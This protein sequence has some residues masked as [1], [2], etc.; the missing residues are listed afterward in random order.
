MT[1][2]P[3]SHE[4]LLFGGFGPGCVLVCN[5]TWAFAHGNWTNVVSST[6]CTA[7]TCP[8]ARA[9]AMMAYY[10]PLNAVLLFGGGVSFL[11]FTTTYNDTWMFYGG[12]WHNV[13]ASVGPAPSPRWAASMAWDSLDNYEVLFGGALA[14][15]QTLGDTWTFDGH[16]HNITASQNPSPIPRAGAAITGSPSGYLLLFG[17]EQWNGATDLILYDDPASCY[18]NHVTWWFYQGHWIIMHYS[19][20]PNGPKLPSYTTPGFPSPCGRVD[21]ALGWSPKNGRFVVYGGYGPIWSAGGRC[22]GT[23][24]DYLND[25]WVY[26]AA[27]GGAAGT[28]TASNWGYAGDTGDPSNRSGMGYASDFTDNYFEIFGGGGASGTYNST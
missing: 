25:T 27:P 23:T 5:D 10:A 16:W 9:D 1:Y 8:S 24:Y 21:A 3:S 17:G 28:S 6:N 12:V 19:A 11:G 13:T 20:C 4:V 14:G 18:L 2:Y 26:L 22:G 7:T 15:G